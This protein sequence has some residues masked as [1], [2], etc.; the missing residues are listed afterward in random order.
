MLPLQ[1]LLCQYLALCQCLLFFF[2][3]LTRDIVFSR[4]LWPKYLI[5]LQP[6]FSLWFIRLIQLKFINLKSRLFSQ[7]QLWQ[8]FHQYRLT[9]HQLIVLKCLQPI[10]FF[11]FSAGR[12]LLLICK[13][14]SFLL[15]FQDFKLKL[16]TQLKQLERTR[17][18]IV[19]QRILLR[20]AIVYSFEDLEK[21]YFCSIFLS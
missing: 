5:T 3:L 9:L 4:N 12:V 13:L 19:T 21:I 10:V 17:V 18:P 14:I 16:V 20:F 2:H 6:S 15:H 1:S 7:L 8:Q 11:S